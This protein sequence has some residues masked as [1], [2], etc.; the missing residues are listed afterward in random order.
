MDGQWVPYQNPSSSYIHSFVNYTCIFVCIFT[1]YTYTCQQHA[2]YIYS[3]SMFCVLQLSIS[4]F[5][6]LSHWGLHGPT[7]TVCSPHVDS[8]RRSLGQLLELCDREV[9][10]HV[11]LLNRHYYS[12]TIRK[13]FSKTVTV[14]L[15]MVFFLCVC[16]NNSYKTWRVAPLSQPLP[17]RPSH[18]T[19]APSS[20]Q[21]DD[22]L[23]SGQR[24]EDTTPCPCM[25]VL[26]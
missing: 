9:P 22:R 26:G 24:S 10:V 8:S 19:V 11:S 23:A 18:D 15:K 14:S 6:T 16:V 5:V 21:T 4:L 3:L 1:S 20:L 12:T 13:P 7:C 2:L 17:L 25:V